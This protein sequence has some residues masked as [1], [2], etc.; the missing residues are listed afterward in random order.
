MYVYVNTALETGGILGRDRAGGEEAE[1]H[2]SEHLV[3]FSALER[4]R[5]S[6]SEGVRE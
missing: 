5:G 6:V 1:E 3:K 4:M 2:S